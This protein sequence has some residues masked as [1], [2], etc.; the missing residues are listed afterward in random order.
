LQLPDRERQCGSQLAKEMQTGVLVLP[1][2]QAQ[3]PQ[4]GAIIKG[5]V[6]E[7]FLVLQLDDLDVHLN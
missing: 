1:R 7:D 6:L 4:T 5:R 3:D 2:I